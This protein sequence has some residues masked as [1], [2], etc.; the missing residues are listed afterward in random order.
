MIYDIVVVGAGPAGLTAAIYAC[1]A[2]KKVLVLEKATFGGQITSSP[3]VENYPGYV[4]M[5]GNEFADKLLEQAMALGTD[6]E[7][8][9]ATAI[10]DK[11]GLRLVRTD[12]GDFTA[13]A[14][15]L[16][17][18]AKHRPLGIAN[19]EKFVGRGISYCAV[20]DGRFF[21]GKDVAV[22]GGGNTALGDALY[23]ANICRSVTLIHR[24]DAFRADR[25]LVD[26]LAGA[27]NIR[28]VMNARVQSIE[29]DARVQ[30]LTLTDTSDHGVSAPMVLQADGVFVAVG[31]VP[32]LSFLSDVEG[33][34]YDP[35]G[36]MITDDRCRSGVPGL[37]AA[38]DVRSKTLRQIATAVSDG[39]IAGT[40]A[41]EYLDG[42]SE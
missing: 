19:E 39:A 25:I 7:M 3:C 30:T 33:V 36:Y 2:D 15:I 32:K 27:S 34:S 35:G 38:G 28:T 21:A 4:K 22:V 24:R 41:V 17:T 26:R 16:A 13:R 40:E 1:R 6:I 9:E 14:V 12:R 10:E 8:A 18:G 11:D 29:G 42:L 23:L 5:S 20:C 37:F 31:S